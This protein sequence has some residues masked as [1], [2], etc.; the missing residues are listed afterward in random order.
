MDW[1]S[2]RADIL[3][4]ERRGDTQDLSQDGTDLRAASPAWALRRWHLRRTADTNTCF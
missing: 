3:S 1:T 2:R 4:V